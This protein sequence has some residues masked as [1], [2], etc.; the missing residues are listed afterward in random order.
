[1]SHGE[2]VSLWQ[3]RGHLGPEQRLRVECV[4]VY[5]VLPREVRVESPCVLWST[6]VSVLHR[7]AYQDNQWT[8]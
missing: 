1:M 3:A 4:Y 8:Q 7:D 6:C 5:L 2:G